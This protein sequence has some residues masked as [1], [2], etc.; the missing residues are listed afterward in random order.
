MARTRSMGE[1]TKGARLLYDMFSVA[2]HEKGYGLVPRVLFLM[3][4]LLATG[5]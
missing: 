5:G 2:S 3:G 4:R 1:A